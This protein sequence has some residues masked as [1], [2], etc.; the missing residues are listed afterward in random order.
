[1]NIGEAFTYG[2]NKFQQNI[3]PILIAALIYFLVFAVIGGIWYVIVGAILG[4]SNAGFFALL[5]S[6][7]LFSL[8]GVVL[9]Y[10]V[11]AGITRGA[12]SLTDGRGLEVATFLSTDNLVQVVI[13]GLV[14]GVATA[15]GFFLCY[16]PGLIV[17][18]FG[19]FFVFFAVDQNMAAMDAIKASIA[20]VQQHIGTLVGF[21]LASLVAL[22]VG[23]LLCGIGLLVAG[24]VVVIAQAFVF[25]RLHGQPVAA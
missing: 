6:S 19:Q 5:L 9:Q 8:G 20:F 21:Y 15:I 17:A 10:L 16:I 22:F 25:R 4:R 24:P 11:Q 18:F 23:A 7:A 2:W 3:G 13:G 14:L 12:L 1:M